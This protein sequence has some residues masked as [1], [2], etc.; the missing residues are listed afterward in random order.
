MNIYNID[1]L[2]FEGR[3]VEVRGVQISPIVVT[4]IK[5]EQDESLKGTF[6]DTSIYY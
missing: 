4:P 5:E 3:L 2:A 6:N 1:A